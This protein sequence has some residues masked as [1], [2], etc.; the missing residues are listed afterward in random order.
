MRPPRIR[1]DIPIWPSGGRARGMWARTLLRMKPGGSIAL[2]LASRTARQ[3]AYATLGKGKFETR[4]INA[5][6]TRIWRKK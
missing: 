4:F 3:L 6:S 5:K 1:Y 2:P